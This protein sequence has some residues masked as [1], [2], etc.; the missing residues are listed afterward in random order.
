[1]AMPEI[2]YYQIFPLTW[3]FKFIRD[4]VFRGAG[5]MD[6]AV[7]IGQFLLYLGIVV[8][9]FMWKFQKE[10]EKLTAREAD[11]PLSPNI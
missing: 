2:M 7:T 6:C 1:M 5:F 9:I 11:M 4:V 8:M 3:E 10:Q